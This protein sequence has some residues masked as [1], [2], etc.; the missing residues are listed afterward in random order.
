VTAH[1]GE[2]GAAVLRERT[3]LQNF[4]RRRVSDPTEAEDVLQDVLFE[5]VEAYRL[6]LPIERAGAWLVSVARNRIVDLFRRKARERS[7]D[8]E[9]RLDLLLPSPDGGPEAAYWRSVLLTELQT[10]LDELPADQ[11]EVFIANELGGTSFKEMASQSGVSINTLLARKRYA[12][13]H[14]RKRLQSIY[15]ELEM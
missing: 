15:D 3:K 5:F 1:D 10:A 7:E 13:L 6:P 11:R 2:I 8:D 9:Q 14:L 4:I 12:V